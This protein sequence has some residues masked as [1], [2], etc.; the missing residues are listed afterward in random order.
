MYVVQVNVTPADPCSL[1]D[2]PLPCLL[3]SESGTDTD[4]AAESESGAESSGHPSTSDL[5]A[6]EDGSLIQSI[7][8]E[9]PF[10]CSD[11]NPNSAGEDRDESLYPSSTTTVLEAL[12]ILF[13]WFSSS[14]GLSKESF[15]RL[16]YI[17]NAYLLPSGNVL[18]TSYHKARTIIDKN[19]VPVEEFHCC[20]NDCVLF[21]NSSCGQYKCDVYPKCGEPR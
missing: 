14:P 15:S 7:D 3:S 2:I 8:F 17:L 5:S 13:S 9:D 20:V 10:N 6:S 11:Y 21:R 16:L 18:P 19:V 4:S 1:K 12:A